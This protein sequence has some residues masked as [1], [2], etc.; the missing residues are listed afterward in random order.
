MEP[1]LTGDLILTEELQGFREDRADAI[2]PN[3]VWAMDFVHDQL[4]TGRKIR[5]LTILALRAGA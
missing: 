2:G 1:L 4:T 3:D 5:I